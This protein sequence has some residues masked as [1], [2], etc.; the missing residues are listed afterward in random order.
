MNSIS[1]P[2]AS[3]AVVLDGYAAKPDRCLTA[4]HH[5]R[6]T[7]PTLAA[8][9]TPAVAARKMDGIRFEADVVG[10]QLCVGFV[11]LTGITVD[12]VAARV[13]GA[14]GAVIPACDRTS[15]SK[16]LREALTVAA[17]AAGVPVIWNARLPV[18]LDG[19]RSGEPDA[20]IACGVVDNLTRYAPVDA[21]H[22]KSLTGT[23]KG[24]RWKVSSLSDPHLASA[25]DTDLG[26]GV[27]HD[28][29]D[30]QLA[31]YHRMLEPLGHAQTDEVW[32]AIIGKEQQVVWRRLDTGHGAGKLSALD[33][34]DTTFAV[35]SQVAQHAAAAKVDPTLGPLVPAERKSA[36]A[37]CPWRDLCAD[38]LVDADDI[39]LLPGI[40]PTRARVH[41]QRGIHK[42]SQLARLNRTAATLIDAGVDVVALRASASKVDPTTSVSGFFT[43]DAH[44][45][46]VAAGVR[47]AADALAVDARTAA[48]SGSGLWNLARVAKAGKPHRARGVADVP[49]TRTTFE[50]DVDIEDADGRCYLIGVADT[51]RRTRDG[52]VRTRTDY[53]A[54]VDWSHSDVGEARVFAEFWA[55]LMGQK[56]KAE[57]NRWGFKVYHYTQHETRYFRHLARAHAGRPGVPT[58]AELEAFFASGAWVDL[59]PQVVGPV[60][61]PTEDHG[62]K[63]LAK[64]A[65]FD[66]RDETPGGANSIAWYAEAIGTD[67]DVADVAR[68]RLLDYNEDDLLAT[69]A[70][71]DWLTRHGTARHL[72]QGLPGVEALDR[73]FAR[74]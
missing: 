11:D 64:L 26:A 71:R 68:Q 23:A 29:D 41:R 40:T 4:L 14:A 39:T 36:C 37:E 58:P 65:G 67:P 35:A 31:H 2:V 5:D 19:G 38:D 21:K 24:R 28:G 47:T 13:K 52:S 6:A 60:I 45:R 8:P 16:Q 27:T 20:L 34:Y 57:A 54:F 59:H 10:P 25:V 53:H 66:W 73:R 56:D 49:V 9:D 3:V 30:S 7:D 62:L 74:R 42:R 33:R 32:G 43:S 44:D 12:Q 72:G 50:L 70:L 63:S 15:E 17:M 69:L 51:W 55:Y 61:W 22:H 1:S 18:D 48:Y 46:I